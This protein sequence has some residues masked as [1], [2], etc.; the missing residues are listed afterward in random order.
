MW[1]CEKVTELS[2]FFA[3]IKK[4]RGGGKGKTYRRQRVCLYECD[5]ANAKREIERKERKMAYYIDRRNTQ[6]I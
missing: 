5:D 1:L 2:I 3:Q 4:R 6:G